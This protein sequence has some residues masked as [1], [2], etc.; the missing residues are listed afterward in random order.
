MLLIDNIHDYAALEHLRKACLH[1]ISVSLH[2]VS[3][4]SVEPVAIG[5]HI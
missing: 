1:F 2:F 5:T 4:G 3:Y